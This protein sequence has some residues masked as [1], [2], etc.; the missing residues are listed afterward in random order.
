VCNA[1]DHLARNCPRG[2]GCGGRGNYRAR[3]ST[4]ALGVTLGG[5]KV[6]LCTTMGLPHKNDVGTQCEVESAEVKLEFAEQPMVDS[7]TSTDVPLQI[8]IFPLQYVKVNI[9]GVECNALKDS[10]C[11]IP[12]VSTR[13]FD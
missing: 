3:G 7:V 11:Q 4:R 1:T 12:V 2:R 9:A 10:G 8:R 6:N 5:P 13:L